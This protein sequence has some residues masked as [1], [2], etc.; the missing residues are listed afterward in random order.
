M[1]QQTL[2]PIPDLL[3]LGLFVTLWLGYGPVARGIGRRAINTGLDAVRTHWM[4]SMLQRDNRIVDSSL[5]GH[6][7]HSAS[8]FAST[9]LIAI[10]ALFGLL[11]GLD[12]V[13]SAIEGLSLSLP[14]SRQL[15]EIKVLLPMAVLVHGLFKLTWSLRQMN[16][17]VALIGAAPPR[18]PDAARRDAL[19]DAIGGVLSGAIQT[20]NAGIRSY[21]FAIAS[22]SWLAGPEWLVFATLGLILILL[23]RQIGSD[24]SRRFRRARALVEAEHEADDTDARPGAT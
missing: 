21:Y 18:T 9:S 22:L 23:H 16:Y 10:G 11:T 14:V 1:P 3:A 7:V 13:Q 24:V 8:F 15:L 19:A 12:R 20:F 5:I 17:T 2:L 6:V 4:R